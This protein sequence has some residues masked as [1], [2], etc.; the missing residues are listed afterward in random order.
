MSITSFSRNAKGVR[1]GAP[2]T[3]SALRLNVHQLK[4]LGGA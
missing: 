1:D 3:P 2:R 4:S